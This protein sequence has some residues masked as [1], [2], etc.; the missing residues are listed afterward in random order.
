[1]LLQQH[2]TKNADIRHASCPSISTH[3]WLRCCQAGLDASLS[4]LILA[5]LL[6][7]GP[8][9]TALPRRI[10]TSGF[11]YASSCSI[12]R[13]LM[14]DFVL[15]VCR[16]A[17]LHRCS[18]G[19]APVAL[20]VCR[21]ALVWARVPRGRHLGAARVPLGESARVAD[22]G[23]A[24]ALEQHHGAVA[25]GHAPHALVAELVDEVRDEGRHLSRAAREHASRRAGE[26][27]ASRGDPRL[28]LG[29]RSKATPAAI[30]ASSGRHGSCRDGRRDR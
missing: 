6:P 10:R 15:L 26:Q 13:Y 7:G 5:S 25:R 29:P 4:D 22:V 18:P 16:R 21:G 27:E 19:P 11:Y 20:L 1:M 28:R 23:S 24:L 3:A 30:K 17:L 2:D 14:H 8:G 12:L 9:C